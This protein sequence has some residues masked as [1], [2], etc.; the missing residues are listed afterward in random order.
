MWKK[1]L[2]KYSHHLKSQEI[3]LVNPFFKRSRPLKEINEEEEDDQSEDD[4]DD[5]PS[6]YVGRVVLVVRDPSEGDVEGKAEESKLKIH[7]L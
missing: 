6:D 7:L 5:H 2:K 3:V 4:A 1:S